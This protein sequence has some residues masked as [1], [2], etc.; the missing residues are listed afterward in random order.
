ML[1]VTPVQSTS[2][3]EQLRTPPR[4]DASSVVGPAAKLYM[5]SFKGLIAFDRAEQGMPK[6]ECMTPLVSLYFIG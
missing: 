6:A 4:K 1:L 2:H 5:N 3:I